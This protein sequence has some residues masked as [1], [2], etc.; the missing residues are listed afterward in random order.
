MNKQPAVYMLAS[1]PW[2]SLYLGVTSELVKRVWEHRSDLVDGFTR[3]YQVHTLVWFEQHETMLSAIG[4]EKAIKAWRRQ[5]KLDLIRK[6]NP[7]WRDL[8]L[9]L[10]R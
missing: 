6:T 2:G 3:R 5:W 8:Y 9:D 1:K 4:R 10:I 7:E